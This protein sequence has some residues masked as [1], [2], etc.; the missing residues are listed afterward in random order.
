MATGQGRLGPLEQ[1]EAARSHDPAASILVAIMQR[2]V[3]HAIEA[4]QMP[5]S[6]TQL[7][8]TSEIWSGS[9]SGSAA[10]LLA[11]HDNGVT[12]DHGQVN[13][14]CKCLNPWSRCGDLNPGPADYE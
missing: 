11:E 1:P 2:H 4:D 10:S 3:E 9:L 7:A 14:A 5:M 12:H 13:G 8:A 6:T